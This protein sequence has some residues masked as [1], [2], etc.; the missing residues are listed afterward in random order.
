MYSHLLGSGRGAIFFAVCR[1]KSS[2]GIDFSDAD[3][4]GVI[5]TGIPYPNL[6]APQVEIKR[7]LLDTSRTPLNGKEWY[8]QQAYKA[9]NQAIGRVIRHV[10]DYGAVLLC[11]E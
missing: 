8:S 7:N 5:L 4:R 3:G 10:D 1:G 2:E 11:D 9:V 6:K